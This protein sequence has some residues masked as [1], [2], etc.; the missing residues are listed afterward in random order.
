L[1]RHEFKRQ[2]SPCRPLRGVNRVAKAFYDSQHI[3]RLGPS[4]HYYQLDSRTSFN[5]AHQ[6]SSTFIDFGLLPGTI[7]EALKW[8]SP[9]H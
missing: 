2:T 3:H 8:F 1:R 7:D 5:A 9:T 6:G 4:F